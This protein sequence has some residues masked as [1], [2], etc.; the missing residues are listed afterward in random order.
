VSTE[1]EQQDTPEGGAPDA[2]TEAPTE[3]PADTSAAAP[4]APGAGEPAEPAEPAAAGEGPG[5][6]VEPVEPAPVA[7]VSAPAPPVDSFRSRLLMPIVLPLGSI[8]VAVLV[9]LNISR[10]FLA[11]GKEQ[12]PAVIIATVITV[13]ILIGAAALSAA[14]HVRTSSLVLGLSLVLVLVFSA[15]LITYGSGAEK[16][17]AAGPGAPTGPP[18]NIIEVDALPSLSFQAKDF[19]TVPGINEI[20]YIDKGGTHTLVFSDP[21]LSYFN[22]AVPSGP[23]KGKVLLQTGD[24]DIYCTIPGHRAAGM[25]AKIHVAA[26][27][28]APPAAGAS[29]TTTTAPGG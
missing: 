1:D 12:A 17:K 11:G 10:L 15:G 29:A 24:Y 5:T 7:A 26:G 3:T 28:V 8:F 23:T 22:L 2:S 9:A 21:K 19:N 14:R 6:D 25:E 4:P 18:V 20:H 27:A 13:G 16:E